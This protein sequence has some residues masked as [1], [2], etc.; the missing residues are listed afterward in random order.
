[1]GAEACAHTHTGLTYRGY[2]TRS[3]RLRSYHGPH[4]RSDL[5]SWRAEQS[6]LTSSKPQHQQSCPAGSGSCQKPASRGTGTTGPETLF[7]ISSPGQCG[8]LR[9][10]MELLCSAWDDTLCSSKCCTLCLQR[11]CSS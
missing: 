5:P 3:Y 11:T 9:S 1:M 10:T 6:G 7:S 8:A 4:T 2:L